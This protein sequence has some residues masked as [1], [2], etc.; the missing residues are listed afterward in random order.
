MSRFYFKQF[1][2]IQPASKE[3]KPSIEEVEDSVNIDDVH[4]TRSY[5]DG[6]MLLLLKDG[7]EVDKLEPA[8]VN[9]SKNG[10]KSV[11][12]VRVWVQ[13]EIRLTP[14]DATRFRE[15]TNMDRYYLADNGANAGYMPPISLS[16]EAEAG[17]AELQDTVEGEIQ[18]PQ[19]ITESNN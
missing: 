6:S 17:E 8:A 13:S 14:E 1:Q 10:V 19:N 3:E 12:K 2:V 18:A 7:H 4:R 9:T 16:N 15:R 5:K 11:V